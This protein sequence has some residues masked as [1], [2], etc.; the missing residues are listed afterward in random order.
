M[1]DVRPGQP[2]NAPV[3]PAGWLDSVVV[4]AACILVASLAIVLSAASFGILSLPIILIGLIVGY[5]GKSRWVRWPAF[6]AVGAV[7]AMYLILILTGR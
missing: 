7:V 1:S 6:S 5:F 4:T 3:R 2:G